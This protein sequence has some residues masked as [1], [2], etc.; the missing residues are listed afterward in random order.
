MKI[1]D[2]NPFIRFA[3]EIN[4]KNKGN[5]VTARDCRIFYVLSG[6]CE[7]LIDDN[8]Y[9]LDKHS[10]FYCTGGSK[11]MIDAENSISIISINFDLSQ[12]SSHMTNAFIPSEQPLP[13]DQIIHENIS[14][15]DYLNSCLYVENG[16]EFLDRIMI[17]VNEFSNKNKYYMETICGT[18]KLILTEL[19][20]V[21]QNTGTKSEKP[22]KMVIKYI[23]NNFSKAITN[24]ELA[25]I[26]GYHEYYLNRLFMQNT[27]QSMHKY[28]LNMRLIEAQHLILNTD[29]PLADISN[30]TGFNNYTHFS[31]YFKQHFGMAPSKYRK[32]HKDNI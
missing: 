15:S 10:L 8:K 13:N 16:T 22:L 4:Y 32:T 1:I 24:K 25:E 18:L 31:E 27:G 23:Q 7:L 30:V 5:F 21:N 26:A 12:S 2:I 29:H 14:D 6:T 28:I 20:K 19:H 11:Y 17:I 3:A 9:T